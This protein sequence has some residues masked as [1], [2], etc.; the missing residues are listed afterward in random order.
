[1]SKKTNKSGLNRRAFLKTSGAAASATLI[2]GLTGSACQTTS[3]DR[4]N[5]LWL[6]IE[7]MSLQF[8]CYGDGYA[9]T[10]NVDRLAEQGVRYT[11][12][13]ATAPLCT[14]ARSSII[15]GVFASSMGTQHLRGIQPKSGRIRC[16][17]EYLREAGYYCSNNVKEDYNFKT[18][19]VAWDESSNTA[20]WRNKQNDQPF[21][22]VFNFMTTHQSQTRYD[23]KKLEEVSADLPPEKRHN[24]DQV[25]VPPYYPETPLIRDNLAAMH[26]QVTL[27]DQQVQ[28]ILDQLESDGLAENTIVFFYSDHGTGLPRGKRWLFESGIRVPLIVRFPEKYKHL[29][30]GRPG[31][32]TDR[33]VSFVDFAPTVLSLAGLNAPGTMHGKAFLGRKKQKPREAVYAIRDRVDEVL[34][35][36][37]TIHDGRY[38][39]IRNFFPHR[40]RMQRSF[41]SEFT[42]IRQEIR[43]L[44][45]EGKL[46]GDAAWLMQPEKP[47][48]ELYDNQTDPKQMFNLADDPAFRDRTDTM[49]KQLYAWMLETEDLSL[50][51]ENDMIE[52]AGGRSPYDAHREDLYPLK[53][54]L[55]IAD[56]VGRGKDAIPVFQKAI[57]STDAAIRYWGATG[58]AALKSDAGAAKSGLLELLDDPSSPVRFAAVEALCYLGEENKAIPVLAKG[59]E[60]KDPRVALHA[61]EILVVVDEKAKTAIPAMKTAIKQNEGK[62]DHAWYMREAL[63]FLVN[64]LESQNWPHD[65]KS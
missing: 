2:A 52:R 39:Y 55:D 56:R 21:F 47:L 59:L 11:Q 64:K 1:M 35:F 60:H 41:Y 44:H 36:S 17:T 58:L 50:L 7:D 37:R 6:T 8:G 40:P 28:E 19:E 22:S 26:T 33:L 62:Q 46:T 25:P 51:H 15:T 10:P 53:E 3:T 14:P 43:R 5:I 13:Y 27:V 31:S 65:S 34:E 30:P 45:A 16:F 12:A 49:R 18:P 38:Q 32:V 61:A 48:E 63:M 57:N 42:P 54:I 4:P 9:I 23:R 29:E 24:P 20:H